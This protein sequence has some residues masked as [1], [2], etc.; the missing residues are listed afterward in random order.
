MKLYKFC[1]LSLIIFFT[2]LSCKKEKSV[3]NSISVE[4]PIFKKEG[5][6]SLF[7]SSGKLIRTIDIEVA[8][9]AYEQEVD[10][11]NRERLK[12]HQGM[13]FLY[14]EEALRGYYMKDIRFPLDLI[15][16]NSDN[17]IVSFSENAT[18]LDDTTFLP[19]QVP[20]Q[21]V[22]K[23]P[24]GLSEEWVLEVGDYVEWKIVE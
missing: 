2:A 19:S 17:K 9:T 7:K 12:T 23:I 13:L 5:E 20:A 21:L 16:I 11:T 22:L 18:P 8:D 4:K 6:L 14:P 1:C 15:F 10:L 24:G 3:E